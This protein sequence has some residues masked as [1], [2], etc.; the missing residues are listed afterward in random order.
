MLVTVAD[1]LSRLH[2]E[3]G[4]LLAQMQSIRAQVIASTGGSGT[5]D[6][7]ISHY[8]SALQAIESRQAAVEGVRSR[9]AFDLGLGV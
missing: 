8:Q 7:I 1:N 5:I 2:F 3:L 4:V 9:I 6:N